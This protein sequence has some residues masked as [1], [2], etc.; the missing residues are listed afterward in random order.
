MALMKFYAVASN[1]LHFRIIF[2]AQNVRK[3]L[4]NCGL[5][6]IQVCNFTSIELSLY[7]L[8]SYVI[9]S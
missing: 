1:F 3:A 8:E 4:R 5:H 9:E 7:V 6:I 2:W